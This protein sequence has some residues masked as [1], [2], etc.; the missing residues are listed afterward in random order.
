MSLIFK[1]TFIILIQENEF[2]E[3]KKKNFFKVVDTRIR[4]IGSGETDGL[5]HSF[6]NL[7]FTGIAS[8]TT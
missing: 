1:F 6:I 5:S 7:I 4:V 2:C 3:Y 8:C